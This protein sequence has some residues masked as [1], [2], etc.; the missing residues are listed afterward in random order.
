MVDLPPYL[1]D[2]VPEEVSNELGQPLLPLLRLDSVEGG[3]VV[4]ED[5][6]R[7]PAPS[8]GPVQDLHRVGR[9]QGRVRP[10]AL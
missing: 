3:A 7:P 10:R 2:V 6:L 1:P 5:R 4:G 9:G 8:Y